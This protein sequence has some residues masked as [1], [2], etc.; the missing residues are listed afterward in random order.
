MPYLRVARVVFLLVVVAEGALGA[1]CGGSP[2]TPA[3]TDGGVQDVGDAGADRPLVAAPD[4]RFKWVNSGFDLRLVTTTDIGTGSGTY[5]I[6]GPIAA[7]PLE[8]SGE[9]VSQYELFATNAN[10]EPM[11]AIATGGGLATLAD[12]LAGRL[13]SQ[14]VVVSLDSSAHG[15]AP[16]DEP[17]YNAILN[18]AQG[19]SVSYQPV[20]LGSFPAEDFPAWVSSQGSLGRVVTALCPKDGALFATSFGLAGDALSYDT[21][22]VTTAFD[23]LVASLEPLASDGYFITALGRDGTGTE[24][25]GKFIVVGTRPAGQTTPR[26]VKVI[27]EPCVIGGGDFRSGEMG[28]LAEG[29]AIVGEIFHGSGACDGSPSWAFI[30]ER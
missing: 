2:S 3:F 19:G 21:R 1:A 14:S 17:T 29:Y 5:T 26:T 10:L 25:E 20:A 4:L 7:T 11:V 27:D 15:L 8:L 24:G 12:D 28:L 6:R 30:G 18:G 9:F 22:V 16:T 13:T 23:G